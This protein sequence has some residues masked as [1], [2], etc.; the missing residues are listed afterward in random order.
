MLFD[1]TGADI[2]TNVLP[3]TFPKGQSVE[4]LR[5]DIFLKVQTSSIGRA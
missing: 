1:K 3:R 4:M 5:S 2:V